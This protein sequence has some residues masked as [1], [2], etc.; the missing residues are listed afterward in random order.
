MKY[1]HADVIKAFVD[2][3]ECE[4]WRE[5]A[6]KWQDINNLYFFEHFEQ[7]RIKPE[8]KP[9]VVAFSTV[10]CYEGNGAFVTQAIKSKMDIH[11][12]K[13]TWDG[14]TCELKSAEVI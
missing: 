11:N 7:V 14:E 12:L 13:L 6:K 8:P 9:D 3:I 2:G 10:Y 5:D 1:K 4:A